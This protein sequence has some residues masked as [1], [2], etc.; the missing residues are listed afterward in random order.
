MGRPYSCP[1]YSVEKHEVNVA[2]R[3]SLTAEMRF[4]IPGRGVRPYAPTNKTFSAALVGGKSSKEVLPCLG[5]NPPP[6]G[7]S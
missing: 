7:R 3:F 2:F 5:T 6:V 1:G 4:G